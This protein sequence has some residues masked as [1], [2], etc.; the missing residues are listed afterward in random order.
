MA[1]R[2]HP[3]RYCARDHEFLFL[4]QP[5]DNRLTVLV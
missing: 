4:V 3:G 5:P 1:K 2:W